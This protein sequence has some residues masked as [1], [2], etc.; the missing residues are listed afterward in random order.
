M[1]KII[2]LFCIFL[3]SCVTKTSNDTVVLDYEDFGPPVIANEVIGMDWWQWEDHGSSRPEKHNIKVVVYKDITLD[4]VKKKFPVVPEEQK[5]YRYLDYETAISYL[6][7]KISEDVIA[8]VTQKLVGS[9]ERL[10]SELQ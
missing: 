7:E 3:L 6:N 5:D 4:V 10:Q 2:V 9:R 1:K 8:E